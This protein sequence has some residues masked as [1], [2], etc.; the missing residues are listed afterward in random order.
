MTSLNA[1]KQPA[2]DLNSQET[3]DNWYAT[4]VAT[5]GS[6]CPFSDNLATLMFIV[7]SDLNEAQR[8]RLTSFLSVRNITVSTYTL[9]T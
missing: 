4:H 3:R 7:G 5:H 1:E 8:E 2:L 9:E 6:P